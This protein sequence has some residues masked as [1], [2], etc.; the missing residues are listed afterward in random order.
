MLFDPKVHV[1]TENIPREQRQTEVNTPKKG[2]LEN[3]RS[4]ISVWNSGY[5]IWKDSWNLLR[6][7]SEIFYLCFH[8]WI[9]CLKASRFLTCVF[10]CESDVWSLMQWCFLQLLNA[11]KNMKLR[12][13]KLF[14][15][16][17]QTWCLWSSKY[18]IMAIA[19]FYW[20]PKLQ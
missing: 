1:P 15:Q 8:V 17:L 20:S 13:G 10:T 4:I 14:L 6:T 7:T 3:F 11:M 16:F 2:T 9:W 5:K 19:P 12:S 18:L